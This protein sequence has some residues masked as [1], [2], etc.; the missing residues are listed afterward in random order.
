MNRAAQTK[1]DQVYLPDAAARQQPNGPRRSPPP[2]S[3]TSD[4]PPTLASADAGTTKGGDRR[5]V[6][7]GCRGVTEPCGGRAGHSATSIRPPIRAIRGRGAAAAVDGSI[8]H[9]PP[10]AGAARPA[11]GPEPAFGGNTIRCQEADRRTTNADEPAPGNPGGHR[12]AFSASHEASR[13]RT[14]SGSGRRGHESAAWVA[15][16]VGDACRRRTAP[17]FLSVQAHRR[18]AAPRLRGAL[19]DKRRIRQYTRHLGTG[20][21]PGAVSVA[22]RE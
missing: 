6:A 9:G 10:P 19:I 20:D 21:Q 8:R 14:P 12:R 18:L 13:A 16:Y 15:P 11:G 3:H 22:L 1:D 17:S 7:G 2:R 5:I 4:A